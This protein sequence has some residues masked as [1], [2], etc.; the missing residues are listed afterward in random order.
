MYMDITISEFRRNIKGYFDSAI[1]DGPVKVVR[2]GV[3]FQ[4]AVDVGANTNRTVQR[5]TRLPENIAE[6][7]HKL[8]PDTLKADL[9]PELKPRFCPNGHA[10]PY[11]KDKCM[12][13]GC[14]YS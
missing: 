11:P 7:G 1:M 4:L 8:K 9:P 6:H 12:G 3:V 2:G 10:I 13:K 5:A 14:K